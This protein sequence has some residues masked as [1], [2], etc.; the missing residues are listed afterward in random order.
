MR[1]LSP[2][3]S[4]YPK[5]RATDVCLDTLAALGFDLAGDPNIRPDLD[6]RPQKS[7]RACVIASDPPTVVHLITRAQG[8]LHD[9]QAFLH[10]AGH[11][12]HYAGCDPTLPYTFRRLSR[13][14]ALTE[15]Y[16]YIV[17]AISREPGW[18]ALHFGLSD[19]EAARSAE[20]TTF[21]EALLYRRYAAK[22]GFELEF[23][24]RLGADGG[25]PDGYAERLTAATGVRY[26]SDGYLSDMDAGFYSADYLR[27]WIRSAQL[28]AKLVA[29]VG[30]DWWRS[31][32]TGELLRGLFFEG[33][34][35]SSE[36]VA[37]RLGLRPARHGPAP[38]RARRAVGVA[39]CAAKIARMRREQ[40]QIDDM[41]AAIRGDLERARARRN[42]TRAVVE[43]AREPEPTA[44]AAP[45]PAAGA[46]RRAE[47]S[48]GSLARAQ[49][50]SRALD[51]SR[52]A[53]SP[54]GSPVRAGA[55]RRAVHSPSP[56][57][58]W[59]PEPVAQ[60]ALAHRQGFL[61]VADR[62]HL[63]LAVDAGRLEGGLEVR[64]VLHPDDAPVADRDDRG[65]AL[66][67]EL[68]PRLERPRVV[69]V[70]G[71]LRGAEPDDDLVA[72]ADAALQLDPVLLAVPLRDDAE[73]LGVV[74]ERRRP[75]AERIPLD[76]VV[77]Q[78]GDRLEVAVDEG[79]VAA[80]DDLHRFE[81]HGD[82]PLD[83]QPAEVGERVVAARLPGEASARLGVDGRAGGQLAAGRARDDLARPAPRCRRRRSGTSS[84][85]RPS[86]RPAGEDRLPP[87]PRSSRPSRRRR[88]GRRAR[89]APPRA[90]RRAPATRRPR[91]LEPILLVPPAGPRW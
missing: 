53:R 49:S 40:S 66:D 28:R 82:L 20:A 17:E 8:G 15:I 79:A 26:R 72:D 13:D 37:A 77:E 64:V 57:A 21:L 71:L 7:P 58:E 83:A 25:T 65:V 33:T 29:D 73:R 80:D 78:L 70:A 68:P 87:P 62:A 45:E 4:T 52:H 32:E 38:A 54:G 36:E 88:G 81:A 6:D 19:E 41:R 75:G 18:H 14:H 39:D 84:A 76:V 47:S 22:L 46:G 34:R 44:E 11:A 55:G 50:R 51:E 42:G 9:Y 1:R 2:L 91:R 56:C 86:H 74:D 31:P 3:E 10:E 43:P 23:W 48:R 24:G 90:R 5:D 16:S 60:K 67:A 12:L 69:L 30:K 85:A 27:A 61:L 89:P 63:A 35:P 59:T